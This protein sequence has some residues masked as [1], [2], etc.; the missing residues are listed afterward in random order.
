ML[1]FSSTHAD[2][3]GVDISATVCLFVFVCMVTDFSG[4]DKAASNFARRFVGVLSRKSPNLGNFA[5]QK[6][7]IGRIGHHRKVLL[8]RY[9]TVD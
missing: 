3:Q 4:E 7:K 2:R 9:D 8:I 5:P 1:F 6:P